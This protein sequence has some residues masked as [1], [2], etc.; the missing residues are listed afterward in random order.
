MSDDNKEMIAAKALQ[1]FSNKGYAGVGVQEICEASG[2]TKPTLYHYFGSKKGLLEYFIETSGK[3]LLADIEQALIY[4]HD[5]VLSLTQV[6]KAEIDFACHNKEYFAFHSVMLNA[7][8]GSEEKEIYSVLIK[9]INQKFSEFFMSSSNEFG[10]MKGKEE[11]YSIL[12]HNKVVSVA[13]LCV[14]G[15]LIADDETI[16]KIIH[17][18]V[19]GYAN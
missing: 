4:K 7:P 16:Y 19:Y 10:N 15:E 17:S 8:S 9:D 3:R 5:L 12:F 11:L 14:R 2:I 18:T 1:L 6:L 13:L